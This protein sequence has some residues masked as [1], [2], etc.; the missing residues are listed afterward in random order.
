MHKPES[1]SIYWYVLLSEVPIFKMDDNRQLGPHS[2]TASQST[3]ASRPDQT[4]FLHSSQALQTYENVNPKLS[5]PFGDFEETL[6][7]TSKIRIKK[8]E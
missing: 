7:K 5:D 4:S 6:R 2:S 1:W 3:A 8:V